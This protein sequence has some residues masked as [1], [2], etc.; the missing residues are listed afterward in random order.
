MKKRLLKGFI[1]IVLCVLLSVSVCA[2]TEVYF[3]LSD[4]IQQLILF[5]I[6]HAEVSIDI[7]MYTFT[8]FALA[9]ALK[10]AKERGVKV[11]IYLDRSQVYSKYGQSRYFIQR[12]MDVRISSNSAIMHN[13]F[14]II[15]G[16][17][18]ITGSYNWT[19]SANTRNDENILVIDCRYVIDEFQEQFERLW[20]LFSP[21]LMEVL[22]ERSK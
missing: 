10:E 21:T 17:V 11:R 6:E 13:K 16:E 1:V 19:L 15:D 7:A 14:A 8:D 12:E 3:S 5:E 18:L 20:L 4:P 22:I 2:K 9:R